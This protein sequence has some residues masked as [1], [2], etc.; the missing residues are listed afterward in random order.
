MPLVASTKPAEGRITS[1]TVVSSPDG[2]QRAESGRLYREAFQRALLFGSTAWDSLL[3]RPMA[4]GRETQGRK[5]SG[6]GDSAELEP[7]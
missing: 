1:Q 5:W 2:Y 4:C 6:W 3:D 7:P